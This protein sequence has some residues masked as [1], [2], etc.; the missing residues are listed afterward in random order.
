MPIVSTNPAIERFLEGKSEHTLQLYHHFVD[1]FSATGA[2]SLEATKTMI[3]IAS[4]KKRIAWVRDLGKNFIHVVFPFRQAYEDNFCFV[5]VAQVPGSRQFN[6]H[7]RIML[8][9]DVNDEVRKYMEIAL[10]AENTGS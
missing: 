6:H 5:K 1:A 4:G 10:S 2:I 9:E 3:G 8:P 7:L